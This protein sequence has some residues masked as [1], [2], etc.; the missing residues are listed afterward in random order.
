[1]AIDYS[2]SKPTAGASRSTSPTE[3]EIL[4]DISDTIAALD[5][6]A[7]ALESGTSRAAWRP[8]TDGEWVAS[9]PWAGDGTRGMSFG[10]CF[11]TP[12]YLPPGTIDRLAIEV[13][14]AAT[15]ASGSVCKLGLAADNGG[16]R[17]GALLDTAGTVSLEST[18]VKEIATSASV[19]HEGGLIWALAVCQISAAG[20]PVIRGVNNIQDHLGIYSA[21]TAGA[22]LTSTV[23]G[24]P[25]QNGVSG[26]LPDPMVIAAY[27][28]S[29]PRVA[30]RFSPSL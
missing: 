23:R 5:T 13:T 30:V 6:R 21:P 4:T 14:T 10:V 18:G 25:Y 9:T 16:A 11:S 3:V 27:S 15:A 26:D 8:T 22:V 2:I 29:I 19:E 17:P 28:A 7:T 20:T 1:M 12:L 24:A